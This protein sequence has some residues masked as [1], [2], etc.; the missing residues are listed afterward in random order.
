MTGKPYLLFLL[1]F[2][3]LTSVALGQTIS[4]EGF[5]GYGTYG[6]H[7]LKNLLQVDLEEVELPI[8]ITENFPPYVNGGFQIGVPYD[9]FE[10][11]FRYG[12]YS[13]GGRAHYKDYS[14]EYGFDVTMNAHMIGGFTRM[15]IFE[16]QRVQLK[17]A[18]AG[19]ASFSYGKIDEYLI[20][21]G[22]KEN[23]LLEVASTSFVLEP[24][25]VPT[26][27]V[28]DILYVSAQLGAA[29]DIGGDLHLVEDRE[30]KLVDNK[31]KPITTNWYGLRT[32]ILLG[33]I[34]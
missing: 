32:G 30:A 14:G 6:M 3:S 25:L 12:H 2:G 9:L 34:L 26:F 1:I 5:A 24:S 22:E 17:V 29:L 16:K 10:T 21:N 13:T 15:A 8:R 27:K 33:I 4:V 20:V 23:L 31:G 28:T 19:L 7:D 11:G 18:V